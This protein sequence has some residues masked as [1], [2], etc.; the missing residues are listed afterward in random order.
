[1]FIPTHGFFN[2]ND[3]GIGWSSALICNTNSS[4][5]GSILGQ[6]FSPTNES[7][8]DDQLSNSHV[9]GFVSKSSQRE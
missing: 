9:S 4:A 5:S 6:W 3:I 8:P 2:I 1:M 7:I